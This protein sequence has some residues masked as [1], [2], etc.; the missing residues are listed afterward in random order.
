MPIKHTAVNINI[1]RGSHYPVK[2][3][4][5]DSLLHGVNKTVHDD[6]RSRK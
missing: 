4:Y 6:A 1:M 5:P 3:K 2:C